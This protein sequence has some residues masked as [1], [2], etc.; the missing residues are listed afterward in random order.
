MFPNEESDRSQTPVGKVAIYAALSP[1]QRAIL[2][3]DGAAW[4]TVVSMEELATQALVPDKWQA[5]RESKPI[6]QVVF[7]VG[8]ALFCGLAAG[9][10]ADVLVVESRD[11]MFGD[12][13]GFP[14]GTPR[15][16]LR[17]AAPAICPICPVC[18]EHHTHVP[19][20]SIF[21][22]K[23]TGLPSCEL[24]PGVRFLSSGEG[25][26]LHGS[27]YRG[28]GWSWHGGPSLW[29]VVSLTNIGADPETGVM[30]LTT[31]R[32]ALQDAPR[33]LL[34]LV[35]AKTAVEVEQP[36]KVPRRKPTSA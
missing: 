20:A 23:P 16:V 35:S 24:A 12:L 14:D 29:G 11:F 21:F 36:I 15:L 6:E 31:T 33:W 10:I 22:V 8:S 28:G 30:G 7:E 34:D 27:P 2:K 4:P 1:E 13:G 17:N 19:E 5:R 32:P 3:C 26:P 18:R 9:T 25:V